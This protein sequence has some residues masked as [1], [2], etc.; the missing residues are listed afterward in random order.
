MLPQA[1]AR[2]N[3]HMRDHGG[4]VEGR[5]AG[6]DAERLAD[7]P[8]VDAGADLLGELALEE[9][10]DAGGELDVFEAAGGFALGV[11]EDFAVLGGDEGG[12][13]V[14]AR[15][16]DFA[17]A[18]HDAGAAEGR[19][20]G[21]RGEGGCGGGDG[22]VEFGAVGEGDAGPAP[23]RWRGCRRCRYG[24][25]FRGR[26]LPSIQWGIARGVVAGAE[27]T[28]G[29]TAVDIGLGTSMDR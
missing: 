7:G 13:F 24:R 19:L 9:L 16:E 10:R 25:R 28:L 2:G 12:D 3:I 17:E 5:D 11:G 18:E 20:R 1:R 15:L 22:G 8:G 14:E 6:D 4:E 26:R 29:R 21:P 27:A 23:G